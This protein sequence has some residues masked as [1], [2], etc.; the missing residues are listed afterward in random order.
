MEET[1]AQQ[2]AGLFAAAA[3]H[4]QDTDI[5]SS[6]ATLLTDA[7]AQGTT[8]APSAQ[9]LVGSQF[10]PGGRSGGSAANSGSAASALPANEICPS[11]AA[12][13]DNGTH[14]NPVRNMNQCVR[15]TSTTFEGNATDPNYGQLIVVFNNICAAAIR[16]TTKGQDPNAT[17]QGELTNVLP[18]QR[19]TMA[20]SQHKQFGYEYRADDGTDC[21]A[22][23][24]RPGCGGQ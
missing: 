11:A 4:R 23:N 15:V 1:L 9:V 18:A 21:F 7:S 10:S 2:Q 8:F 16:L 19:Y 3:A 17:T 12:Y 22:N 20:V 6:G 5:Q 24:L 14:C 13:P